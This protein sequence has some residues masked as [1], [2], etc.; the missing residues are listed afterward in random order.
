L[1]R[2]FVTEGRGRRRRR[3]RRRKRERERERE[4]RSKKEEESMHH[5]PVWPFPKVF[6]NRYGP[7]Y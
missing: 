3:R 4:K 7:T 6:S 1:Q 5:P 2:R